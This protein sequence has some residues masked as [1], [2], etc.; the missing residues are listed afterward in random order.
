MRDTILRF[1]RLDSAILKIV[2]DKAYLMVFTG[3]SETVPL[4]GS[5]VTLGSE[6]CGKAN[7]D[8]ASTSHAKEARGDRE[9]LELYE[10]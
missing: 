5:E 3:G 2:P 6:E 9:A 1:T 10:Q 4:R 8:L 7:S